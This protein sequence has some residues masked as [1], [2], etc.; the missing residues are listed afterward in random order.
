MA[1]TDFKNISQVCETFDCDLEK[2]EFVEEKKFECDEWIYNY[3]SKNLETGTSYSSEASIC[4]DIIKPIVK[5]VTDNNGLPVW[6]HVQFDV[7]KEKG[8]TGSPD[9]LFAPAMRGGV[10]FKL[11]VVCLGE[12]KKDKFDEAWGQTA[13]EMVAAQIANKNKEVAI[14]GLATNGKTW[15]FGKLLGDLFTI[16]TKPISVNDLQ[17][18]FNMLNWLFCE[19]RKSADILL[20]IEAKKKKKK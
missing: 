4:E 12:A 10:A 3:I 18:I 11:P 2:K 6:S 17:Q 16:E 9:Y 5:I 19:S 7:D 20:E 14:Y 8:L 13:A 1:Y 15:E